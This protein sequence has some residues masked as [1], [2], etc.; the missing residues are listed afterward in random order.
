MRKILMVLA[1]AGFAACGDSGTG[2]VSVE[3]TYT[4]RS[5]NGTNLPYI[6][7]QSGTQKIEVVDDV[8]SLA[9]NGTYTEVGHTRTTLNGQVTTDTGTDNGSYTTAGTSIT[10]RSSDGSSTI[11]T[12]NGGTLTVVDQGLSAVFTR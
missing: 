8:I 10:L 9:T 11:G 2:L 3:G 5:I 7:L 4:L 1:L 12:I 6:V